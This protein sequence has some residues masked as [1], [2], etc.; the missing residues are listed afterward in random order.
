LFFDIF[1]YLLLEFLLRS[2]TDELNNPTTVSPNV[3][4]VQ[5]RRHQI[6]KLIE[7]GFTEQQARIGL[8][9]TRFVISQSFSI[10]HLFLFRNDLHAAMELLLT[11]S[12]IADDE[13]D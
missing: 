5:T 2:S 9:R 10:N 11:Q 12:D 6:S 8:K 4:D 1:N 3:D 13:S 7:L